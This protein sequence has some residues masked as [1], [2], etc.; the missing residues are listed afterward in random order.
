MSS[1][2]DRRNKLCNAFSWNTVIRSERQ[3]L[4]NNLRLTQAIFKQ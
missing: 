3:Y 2:V 4:E 1:R